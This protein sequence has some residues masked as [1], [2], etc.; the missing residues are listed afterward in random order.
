MLHVGPRRDVD[1]G[2]V[3]LFVELGRTDLRFDGEDAFD[4]LLGLQ[5][6][7]VVLIE[8][9][10]DGQVAAQVEFAGKGD[11]C[12][13]AFGDDDLG[14]R[15]AADVGRFVEVQRDRA[16]FGVDVG[17]GAG[18]ALALD[19][20][21]VD[22]DHRIRDVVLDAGGQREHRDIEE[23]AADLVHGVLQKDVEA[24][25]DIG[26]VQAEQHL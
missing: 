3:F 11:R 21:D 13:A 19:F 26:Q 14:D 17:G 5:R 18:E 4:L 12:A 22:G 23:Q 15:H 9:Q 1:G 6:P 25:A 20:E 10:R 8:R 7:F 2:G 16:Q 24:D